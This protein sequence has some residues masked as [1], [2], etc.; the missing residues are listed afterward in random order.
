M[1]EHGFPAEAP[2]IFEPQFRE[3]PHANN[4]FCTLFFERVKDK[5]ILRR[6]YQALQPRWRPGHA[7]M[8]VPEV[9]K[10][11]FLITAVALL[12]LVGCKTA[13]FSKKSEDPPVELLDNKADTATPALEPGLTPAVARRF[14]DVPLP[15]GLHEDTERTFVYDSRATKVARMVYSSKDSL[16]SLARFYI[17]QAPEDGWKL[18]STTQVDDSVSLLFRKAGLRLNVDI[19]RQGLGRSN[20]LILLYLPE[21]DGS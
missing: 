10:Y 16:R 12:A 6:D 21:N 9:M 17:K 4:Q 13:P 18:E 8:K 19:S 14:K 15:S 5:N 7:N 11:N 3:T 20:R 2:P 1:K